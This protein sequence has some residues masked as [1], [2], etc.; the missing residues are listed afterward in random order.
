MARVNRACTAGEHEVGREVQ[1]PG[2]AA[3]R[4]RGDRRAAADDRRVELGPARHVRRVHDDVRAVAHEQPLHRLVVAHVEPDGPALR[5]RPLVLRREHL[6]A[7][8]KRLPADLGAEIAGA[9]R[10]EQ[11]HRTIVTERSSLGRR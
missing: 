9:A 7:A 6:G 5:R 11:L 10:H 4:R 1:E 2:A 3:V 8:R